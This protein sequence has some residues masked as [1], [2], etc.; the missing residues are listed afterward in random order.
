MTFR[1]E[2]IEDFDAGSDRIRAARYGV[3]ETVGAA[4]VAVHL[5]PWP[6]LVSL[7]EILPLGPR[8]HAAGA[9]DRCLL[10]YNQPWRMPNFLALKYIVSTAGT[11]YATVRAALSVLD[12]IA[13]LKRTDAIVCDAGNIRLSDRLFA[14]F[15]W[16][17]H[18]PQRWHRNYIRRFYGVYPDKGATPSHKAAIGDRGIGAKPQAEIAPLACAALVASAD[19]PTALVAPAIT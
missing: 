15:G 13:E 18:K 2:T 14:R 3:I 5:R 6:K 7:P 8:Y 4:L 1:F 16:E 10:Y 12:R 11:S 17:P 9:P 19:G